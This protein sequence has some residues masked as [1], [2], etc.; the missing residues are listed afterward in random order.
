MP[1]EVLVRS[2][3]SK[4]RFACAAS[5][6]ACWLAVVSVEGADEG[7]DGSSGIKL[8]HKKQQ[9]QTVSR[10]DEANTF[11]AGI[12]VGFPPDISTTTRFVTSDRAIK[13]FP[14]G[15]LV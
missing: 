2:T 13:P 1:A 8:F 6:G 9:V 3:G 14:S 4:R 11:S 12:T 10:D 7:M 15:V 5:R